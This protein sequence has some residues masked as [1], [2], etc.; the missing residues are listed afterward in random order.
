MSTAPTPLRIQIHLLIRELDNHLQVL[1][2]ASGLGY[3]ET[4]LEAQL[5]AKEVLD[6]I[7]EESLRPHGSVRHPRRE[8]DS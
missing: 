5:V 3:Y 7:R 4:A 8:L 2:A 1:L 6:A